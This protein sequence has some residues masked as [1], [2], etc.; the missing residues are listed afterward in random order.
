M[1]LDQMK[2]MAKS[3][4]NALASSGLL[5]DSVEPLRDLVAMAHGLPNWQAVKQRDRDLEMQEQ[6]VR[7]RAAIRELFVDA[8]PPTHALCLELVA[9]MKGYANWNS[10]ARTAAAGAQRL[11]QLGFTSVQRNV[12]DKMLSSDRGMVVV[13]SPINSGRTSSRRAIEHR[14][15]EIH[16]RAIQVW[17][18]GQPHPLRD[19]SELWTASDVEEAIASAHRDKV[20]CELHAAD[21]RAALVRMIVI[22][23][24]IGSVLAEGVVAG[25]VYQRFEPRRKLCAEVLIPDARLLRRLSAMGNESRSDAAERTPLGG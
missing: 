15:Q 10:A 23:A 16:G 11:D 8:G 1:S 5:T 2:K 9:R 25:V 3:L 17:R 22:G 12:I 13:A 14:F 4:K 6:V 20:I 19:P 24:P 18:T 7:L 21:A